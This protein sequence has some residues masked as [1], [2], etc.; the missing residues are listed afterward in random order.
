MQAPLPQPHDASGWA[1]Q[2]A[3]PPAAIQFNE[4]SAIVCDGGFDEVDSPVGQSRV[5]GLASKEI[6]EREGGQTRWGK[7]DN[8]QAEE[9]EEGE[10]Q[11]RKATRRRDSSGTKVSHPPPVHTP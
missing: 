7:G 2:V 6:R 8:K 9:E 10:K 1:Q 5:P 4:E 11:G 3:P